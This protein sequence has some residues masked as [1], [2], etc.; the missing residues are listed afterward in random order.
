MKNFQFAFLQGVSFAVYLIERRL[1]RTCLFSLLCGLVFL[2]TATASFA[3]APGWSR[4]QQNL[5]ISYDECVRRMP[6]ALQAEGYSRDA[7]SGGNFVA[8]IRGV[9][10]A[11][12]ICS[13]A[14][15]AR[16]LVQIVVA[17]NGDGGGR[18]RERLQ[19]QM[20]RPGSGQPPGSCSAP[21]F[22]N[23]SFE[24]IENDRSLGTTNFY[25]DGSTR[26]TWINVPHIWRT[27]SNGDLMVYG[28]GTRWVTRLKFDPTTCTFR[29][30]RDRTSQTQDGVQTVMRPKQ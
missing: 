20:E 25:R 24:W 17:S 13:P 21:D 3:Q 30:T 12:I 9:H 11:V 14:P 5:A 19:A 8:G 18:E 23:T 7:N 2:G 22:F 29:G 28:D 27:D 16:M 4:G 15:D 1:A 26:L 6:A 10:T